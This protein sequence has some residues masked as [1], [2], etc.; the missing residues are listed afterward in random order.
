MTKK[1]CDGEHNCY[2][3]LEYVISVTWEDKTETHY[4]CREHTIKA[5]LNLS[6]NL[7]YEHIISCNIQRYIF[8]SSTLYPSD[9]GK[10]FIKG[11]D[12]EE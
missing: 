10:G 5:T 9:L 3:D 8:T 7:K 11:K 6:D 12:D 1:T 2:D 4:Y